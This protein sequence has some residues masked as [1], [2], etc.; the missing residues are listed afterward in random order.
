MGIGRIPFAPG[1]WGSVLGIGWFL[2]L[3]AAGNWWVFAI[4][5]VVAVLAAV[6]VCGRAEEIMQRRDPPSVVLDEIVAIPLCMVS[7]VIAAHIDGHPAS[8]P[9]TAMIN[10]SALL[11]AKVSGLWL[12]I[13]FVLFRFFDIWK[14]WPIRQS[15][16]LPGGWGVVMDDVLA[17]VY[18]NLVMLAAWSVMRWVG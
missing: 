11:T 2:L 13:G 10:Q 5:S 6:R 18:V 16:R 17:A 8:E 15:Q 14:P 4:G 7:L 12:F 9:G 3:V 1:T